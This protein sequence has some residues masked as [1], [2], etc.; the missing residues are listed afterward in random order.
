MPPLTRLEPQMDMGKS[1]KQ[2]AESRPVLRSSTAEGGK[3]K[4]EMRLQTTD[5]GPR[6]HVKGKAEKLK[7][8]S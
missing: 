3:Q 6:D 5:Y 1:R 8:E 4:A 7:A 2:K